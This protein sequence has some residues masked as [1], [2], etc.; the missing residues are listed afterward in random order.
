MPP[1]WKE[2]LS[3]SGHAVPGPCR[4]VWNG[5]P[6]RPTPATLSACK[7]DPFARVCRDRV[8]QTF[9]KP[10]EEG[11]VPLLPSLPPLT[12]QRSP[13]GVRN[14]EHSPAVTRML[15]QNQSG[16]RGE[17]RGRKNTLIQISGERQLRVKKQ[18]KHA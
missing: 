14:S 9:Q 7:K 18:P 13:L 4:T 16:T 6:G 17:W 2:P 12:D 11:G 5:V 3:S 1:S 15:Q 8:P 10:P